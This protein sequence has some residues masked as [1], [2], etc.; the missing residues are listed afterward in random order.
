MTTLG[1]RLAPPACM[2]TPGGAARFRSDRDAIDDRLM[3][4]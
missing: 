2:E 4:K 1:R 3:H